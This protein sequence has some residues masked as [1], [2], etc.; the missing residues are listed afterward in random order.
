MTDRDGVDMNV[1][2]RIRLLVV[3]YR[4]KPSAVADE[5]LVTI[6]FILC[7]A[8]LLPVLGR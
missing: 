7:T 8:E 2:T 1:S 5:K 4:F 6:L 3:N